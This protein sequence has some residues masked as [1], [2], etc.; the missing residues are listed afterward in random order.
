M[1]GIEPDGEI[2]AAAGWESGTPTNLTTCFTRHLIDEI[3]AKNGQA[4]TACEL[5]ANLMTNALKSNL[6]STPIHRANLK[7]P[8]VLFHKIG[9]RRAGEV[10]RASQNAAARVLIT[11]SVA[12][13]RLPDVNEWRTWMTSNMPRGRRPLGRF[14]SHRSRRLPDRG[15]ELSARRP[16]L[17]LCLFPPGQR[18]HWPRPRFCSCTC[19]CTCAT[20][21]PSSATVQCEGRRGSSVGF[22]EPK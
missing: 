19:T 1:A 8:S 11:V 5:H 2:L 13:D 6:R 21:S 7:Y 10:V 17:P 16:I 20:G 18:D 15:L 3:R 12:Q 4:F 14:F 22:L 9:T